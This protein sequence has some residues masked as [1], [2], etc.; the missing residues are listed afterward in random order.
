MQSEPG[1]YQGRHFTE[2]VDT[3]RKLKRD[4]QLGATLELLEHLMEATEA[5]ARANNW[6]VAPWS[7]EQAAIVHNK[8]GD[9]AA[10]IEVLER[11]E[12]QPKAPGVKPAKLAERLARLRR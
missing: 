11:F 4:G 9:K 5:E 8:R 1:Q 12:R 6:G 2:W 7:Y 3:V 10:E